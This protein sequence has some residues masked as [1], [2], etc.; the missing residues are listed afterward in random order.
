ME[1]ERVAHRDVG[2]FHHPGR[3]ELDQVLDLIAAVGEDDEV[4]EDD[5]G[6]A[7]QGDQG[8]Y[9]NQGFQEGA[10]VSKGDH[11]IQIVKH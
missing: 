11:P 6:E 3:V 7:E 1:I 2:V 8:E 5:G 9:D 10:P 4:L